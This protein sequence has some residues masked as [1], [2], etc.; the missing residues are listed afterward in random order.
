[1]CEDTSR[2]AEVDVLY[3]HKRPAEVTHFCGN[4][5]EN[6][7]QIIERKHVLTSYQLALKAKSIRKQYRFQ[8]PIDL[9]AKY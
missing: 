7:E 9:F 8:S 6:K 3:R 5:L 4:S 2:D 1:M